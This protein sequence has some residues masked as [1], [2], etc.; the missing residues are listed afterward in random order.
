[1]R[2]SDPLKPDPGMLTT[3]RGSCLRAAMAGRPMTARHLRVA[4]PSDWFL[5]DHMRQ[6]SDEV[7]ILQHRLIYGRSF[8][9]TRRSAPEYVPLKSEYVRAELGRIGPDLIKW[10]IQNGYFESTRGY[11]PGSESYAYKFGWKLIGSANMFP[12]TVLLTNPD[13]LKKLKNLQKKRER[14]WPKERK[15]LKMWANKIHISFHE[16]EMILKHLLMEGDM[17]DLSFASAIECILSIGRGEVFHTFCD[18][19]RA[20]TC[21]SR[22]L[23]ELRCCLSFDGRKLTSIDVGCSQPLILGATMMDEILTGKWDWRKHAVEA[24]LFKSR[25]RTNL[26]FTYTEIWWA[27]PLTQ[28]LPHPARFHEAVAELWKWHGYNPVAKPTPV[29]PKSKSTMS[30]LNRELEQWKKKH[31][32]QNEPNG[33]EPKDGNDQSSPSQDD[34][35]KDNNINDESSK[36]E[37]EEGVSGVSSPI[38]WH[39]DQKSEL[40]SINEN[41]L[42]HANYDTEIPHDLLEFIRLCGGF[43]GKATLYEYIIGVT[44][45]PGGVEDRSGWKKVWFWWLYGKAK[46]LRWRGNAKMVEKHGADAVANLKAINRLF[47]EKFPNVD[48]WVRHKKALDKGGLA[49]EMQKVESRII[50]G[51]VVSILAKYHPTIAFVTIHDSFLVLPEHVELIKKLMMQA[52]KEFGVQPT[53]NVHDHADDPIPAAMAA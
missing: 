15:H 46:S 20:H 12:Q 48:R 47:A 53:L 44:K 52:F 7:N 45:W 28:F 22:L 39:G 16:C 35:P 30:K 41:G 19:G 10:L 18:Q 25:P 29:K 37:M 27:Q 49:R 33:Q 32:P 1:M 31:M 38:R 4:Q 2:D 3:F 24:D 42:Q 21:V 51:K 36:S 6:W 14:A 8:G 26:R 40:N 43:G 13:L 17:S 5:P 9:F 34:G 50:I 23:K 11:T